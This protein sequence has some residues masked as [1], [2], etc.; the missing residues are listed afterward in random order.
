MRG[1]LQCSFRRFRKDKKRVTK[2]LTKSEGV[3]EI[4]AIF[5][6]RTRAVSDGILFLSLPPPSLLSAFPSD[7]IFSHAT[8][9]ET[10]EKALNLEDSTCCIPVGESGSSGA[11]GRVAAIGGV[12]LIRPESAAPVIDG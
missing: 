1:G 11:T 3:H 6:V 4:R 8:L 10:G 9:S 5:V 12:E 7:L 2:N